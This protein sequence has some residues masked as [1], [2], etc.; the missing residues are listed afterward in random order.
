[1]LVE[2]FGQLQLETAIIGA[3]LLYI[4]NRVR[5]H[6]RKDGYFNYYLNTIAWFLLFLGI[7]FIVV[8]TGSYFSNNYN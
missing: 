1:M 2:F 7:I 5:E 8:A 4:G 6:V 3:F